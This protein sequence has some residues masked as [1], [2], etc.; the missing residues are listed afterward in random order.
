MSRKLVFLHDIILALLVFF[1]FCRTVYFLLFIPKVGNPLRVCIAILHGLLPYLAIFLFII[2]GVAATIMM[3][4]NLQDS[5]SF[6]GKGDKL[7]TLGMK[8][9]V[10]IESILRHFDLRKL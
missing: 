2:I 7:R 6:V 3:V 5:G 9:S 1:I 8:Y 4:S 10:N